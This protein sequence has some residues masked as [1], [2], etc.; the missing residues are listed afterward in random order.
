MKPLRLMKVTDLSVE[1]TAS[2]LRVEEKANQIRS[3]RP[4]E[5]RARICV[6]SA[7]TDKFYVKKIKTNFE[8]DASYHLVTI[9]F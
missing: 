5:Y 1:H 3:R 4:L 2:I 6:G 7:T 8:Q 9:G